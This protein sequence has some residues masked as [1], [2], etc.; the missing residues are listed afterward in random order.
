MAKKF[1]FKTEMAKGKYRSFWP[2]QHYIKL[3][4]KPVGNIADS[5]YKIRLMVFDDNSD[6]EWHWITLAKHNSCLQDAKDFLNERFE[7][8]TTKYR[9]RKADY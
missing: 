2:D 8:I 4:G 3:D 9:L 5:E 1:T 7:N 6:T